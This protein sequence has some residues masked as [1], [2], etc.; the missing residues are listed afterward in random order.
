MIR[1]HQAQ[2]EELEAVKAKNST[3]IANALQANKIPNRKAQE[4]LGKN[5]SQRKKEEAAFDKYMLE[6]TVK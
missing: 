4:G 5:S 6:M 2:Y 3:Y 1:N